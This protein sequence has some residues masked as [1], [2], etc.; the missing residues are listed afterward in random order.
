MATT[1]RTRR[2]PRPARN[3][4]IE[5]R[6]EDRG[7]TRYYRL[8]ELLL[9]ALRDGTIAAGTLL[10]SEPE[11]C[12]QHG[13]SRTT[14]RRALDRLEGEGLI[15]RRRGSGTYARAQRAVPRL[16]LELHALPRTVAA[17]E[18]QSTATTRRLTP[19]PVPAALRA[20]AA[21]IGPTAC[22][23]ERLRRSHGEPLA[24]TALY[25]PEPTGQRIRRPLPERATALTVLD[26]LGAPA[27][28]I[29]CWVGAVAADVDAARALEVPLG[30]P[31]IRLRAVLTDDAGSPCAVLESLCRSD[32]LRLTMLE[33]SEAEADPGA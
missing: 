29:R 24:L 10:P 16:C 13:L 1:P 31:L 17:L 8:Y 5:S 33:R 15:V 19:A 11:L 23:I 18:A 9:A 2:R 12:T 6:R 32:R 27:T 4:G 14:V 3:G 26:R 28:G 7:V 30:S 21:D 20:V 25:L 22:L